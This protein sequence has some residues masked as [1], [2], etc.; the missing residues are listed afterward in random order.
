MQRSPTKRICLLITCVVVSERQLFDTRCSLLVL[1]TATETVSQSLAPVAVAT[2]NV[3]QSLAP[4]AGC[5]WNCFTGLICCYR[6]CFTG[7]GD[8]FWTVSQSLTPVT[9]ATETVSHAL[10]P[11]ALC[12]L[13][14]QGHVGSKAERIDPLRF[15]AR[16]HKRRLDQS[17]SVLHFILLRFLFEC[18]FLST[19]TVWLY[20]L[21]IMLLCVLSL[22]CSGL[23]DRWLAFIAQWYILH[24]VWGNNY[25]WNPHISR[26]PLGPREV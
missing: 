15:L 4:V 18:V 24:I 25:S 26:E 8:C 11:V 7:L 23:V 5:Y 10:A 13:C 9:A 19:T 2:E 22:S 16:C 21:F 1:L 14:D 6:K 12:W 17:P 3:S 20:L